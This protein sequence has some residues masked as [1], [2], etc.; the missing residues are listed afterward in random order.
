M[1][2]LIRCLI[3]GAAQLHVL[4]WRRVEYLTLLG[5]V[6]QETPS[7]CRS[8]SACEAIKELRWNVQRL[9]CDRV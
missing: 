6:D 4:V 7:S 5:I 1:I 2:G 9:I 8:S 3:G